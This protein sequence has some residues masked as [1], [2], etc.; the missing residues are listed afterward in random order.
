M[1]NFFNI[2]TN[3]KSIALANSGHSIH[4]YEEDLLIN[5]NFPESNFIIILIG[6]TI[7]MVTVVN[8]I[9]LLWVKVKEK[10]LIHKMVTLDCVANIM[11][12]GL[13]LPAFPVRICKNVWLCAAITFCRLCS[14]TLNR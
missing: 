3:I 2:S 12:A 8:A 9:V 5:Q 11:M 4:F 6:M 10:V 7:V 1:S 14:S 13:L